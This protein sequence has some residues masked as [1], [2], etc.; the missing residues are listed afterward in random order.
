MGSEVHQEVSQWY[1]KRGVGG[2]RH[3]EEKEEDS[4]QEGRCCQVSVQGDRRWGVLSAP[5]SIHQDTI[6]ADTEADE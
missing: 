3:D 4:H 5:N 1:D 6:N 2:A